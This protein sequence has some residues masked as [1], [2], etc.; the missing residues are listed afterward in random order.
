MHLFLGHTRQWLK[1]LVSVWTLGV[2][3]LLDLRSYLVG[4]V[5]LQDGV[6]ALCIMYIQLIMKMIIDHLIRIGH[7]TFWLMS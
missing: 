3:W 7:W 5:P 4:D 2:A 6:S 1:R